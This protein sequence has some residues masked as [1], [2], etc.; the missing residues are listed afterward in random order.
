MNSELNFILNSCMLKLSKIISS[1]NKLNEKIN[2]GNSINE[3]HTA[4]KY[5]DL[6][7]KM[8]IIQLLF[9]EQCMFSCHISVRSVITIVCTE[10]HTLFSL[11][12]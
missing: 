1:F 11:L 7:I 4:V 8:I 6:N 2:L 5:L 3:A 10:S 12:T 9:C